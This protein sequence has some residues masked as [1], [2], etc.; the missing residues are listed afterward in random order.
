MKSGTTRLYRGTWQVAVRFV[1][2]SGD[3]RHR[4]RSRPDGAGPGTEADPPHDRPIGM[5]IDRLVPFLA[6]AAPG[7]RDPG[8]ERP[9]ILDDRVLRMIESPDPPRAERRAGRRAGDPWPA[10]GR[11][12]KS[13]TSPLTRA[14]VAAN[15]TTQVSPCGSRPPRPRRPA[16]CP[17]LDDEHG[18]ARGQLIHAVDAHPKDPDIAIRLSAIRC[19]RTDDP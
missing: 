9:R 14:G 18:E 7:W 10:G 19:G 12:T 6:H 4:A 13:R 3:S 5:M 17:G 16:P 15:G 1:R 8:Q 11:Q 2:A